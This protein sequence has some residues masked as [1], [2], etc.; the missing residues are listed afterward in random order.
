ML[1]AAVRGGACAHNSSI[2]RSV[3]TTSLACNKRIARSERWFGPPS[4][5]NRSCSTTSN[6]PRTRN[7][8]AVN[9]RP[10]ATAVP[11]HGWGLQPMAGEPAV[12]G[13]SATGR[14]QEALAQLE[15]LIE[16]HPLCERLHAP[17]APA[18]M[19]SRRPPAS[20]AQARP[21]ERPITGGAAAS[22]WRGGRARPP[23]LAAWCNQP[24]SAGR[25]APP[26]AARAAADSCRSS[27]QL[28]WRETDPTPTH[29]R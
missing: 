4:S 5:S 8:I 22:R 26:R 29:E 12:G 3:E 1:F 27:G 10:E 28:A 24:K 9:R 7:S 13:D 25:R 17:R 14:D 2:K 21:A 15:G 20:P 16:E 18:L 11:N 19:R 6:G 23:V